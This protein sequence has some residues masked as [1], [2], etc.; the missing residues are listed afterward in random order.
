MSSEQIETKQELNLKSHI[1]K[2]V[3]WAVLAAAFLIV[4]IGLPI[5]HWIL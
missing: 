2:L 1:F 4:C 3:F 5:T